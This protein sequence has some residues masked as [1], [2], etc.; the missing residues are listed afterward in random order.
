MIR[1]LSPTDV[2]TWGAYCVKNS[3]CCGQTAKDGLIE[4]AEVEFLFSGVD[5]YTGTIFRPTPGL[6][7]VLETGVG[8]I[9]ETIK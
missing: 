3:I 8:R 6:R 2:S 9:G 5:N 1:C 4:R 7:V